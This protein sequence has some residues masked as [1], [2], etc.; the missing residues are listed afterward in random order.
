MTCTPRISLSTFRSLGAISGLKSSSDEWRY[1][2]AGGIREALRQR[3][4]DGFRSV[5]RARHPA[6][7]TPFEEIE[8]HI[9]PFVEAVQVREVNS[10]TG[11][12][13]D[14]EREPSLK[15]IAIGGNRL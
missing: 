5:T 8:P 9:G 6:L 1:H 4:E 15:A 3:W 11:L 2:R 10:A 7:D 12:V 13:L 14:Y